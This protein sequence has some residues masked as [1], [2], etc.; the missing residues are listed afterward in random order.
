[1][2][3]LK[4]K[5]L[6]SKWLFCLSLSLLANT[7]FALDC[8]V[9]G[10][11]QEMNQCAGDDFQK[12]DRELNQVYQAIFKKEKNNKIY[13]NKLQTS[14]R[15]WI[16]FRDAE[17]EAMFACKDENKRVC[18]GSM[19]GMLYPHAKEALTR[20]RIKRLKTYLKGQNDSVQD[21]L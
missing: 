3:P 8:N 4:I 7:A 21:A 2:K 11:Q 12:A 5:P 6:F 19:Y 16:V 18:W 13:L 1:M 17:L 9:E 10:T 14:Q 20:E 15:A